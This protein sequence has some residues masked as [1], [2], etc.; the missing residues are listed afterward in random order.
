M[1]ASIANRVRLGS[2]L[3]LFVG[4]GCVVG[5]TGSLHAA[6]GMETIRASLQIVL[7]HSDESR[8]LHALREGDEQAFTT[9][10]DRYGP[11]M[12]RF[13]R[14]VTTDTA[15][16]EDCLQEAWLGVLKGL[17][18]FEE[19]AS[20]RTWIFS[21]LL[22]RLKSR[23]ERERRL[24]PFSELGGASATSDDSAVE[25]ERFLS[26]EHPRWPRHWREDPTSWG[27]S[28]EV[29]LLSQEVRAKVEQAV[30]SLAPSQR[31]VITL[32]DIEG[33]SAEEV[34]NL[35]A[36]TETNQRVLL[37]RARSR[38]RRALERYFTGG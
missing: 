36:I 8:L 24:V 26:S 11:A 16:A 23:L 3:P 10:V 7:V 35:L 33:F 17:E 4:L 34:C 5:V 6:A 25:P 2:D 13:A 30:A 22:N 12:M 31:A 28:P 18:R 29:H 21:I 37:H 27:A 32:R 9:L 20:L 1:I 14:M 38:V 19:R 15:I